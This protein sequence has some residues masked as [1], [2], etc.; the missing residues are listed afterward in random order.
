MDSLSSHLNCSCDCVCGGKAKVA[1]FLED[2]R[3]L[4]FLMSLNDVYAQVRGNI[5]MISPLPSMDFAYSL[6]LQDENQRETFVNLVSPQLNSNASSF[7]VG[8]QQKG[9]QRY[10]NQGQRDGILHQNLETINNKRAKLR[11]PN[12]TLMS[13]ALIA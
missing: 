12:I 9:A 8:A 5:L 3:I 4:E 11:R 6:L 7:M 1:K 10:K 2:Q 13:A